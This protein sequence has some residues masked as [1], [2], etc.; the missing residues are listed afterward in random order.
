[1]KT[2]LLL[3]LGCVLAL[4]LVSAQES[5]SC[6]Y[7]SETGHNVCGSFLEFFNSHGGLGIFGYPLT[8]EMNDLGL[9]VQ[10]FQH[11]RMEYHPHNPPRY[12]VQ[13]GLLGDYFAPADQKARI[14]DSQKPRSNDRSRRYFPETGHSVGFSFLKFYD[15]KGG[16][17][18]F[19]YPVTEF[20]LEKGRFVQYFQ[21]A[22]M[23]WDPNQSRITLHKLGEMWIDQHPNNYNTE[24]A[25]PLMA[26]GANTPFP[27]RRLFPR[28]TPRPLC[29]MPLRD[30][31]ATRPCGYTS[32]VKMAS[33]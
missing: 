21:R 1:M 33:Q 10:Y 15:E 16:L 24:R 28:C 14:P 22:L 18:I 8:E 5:S 30:E 2:R 7:F 17:D 9:L 26:P 29:V 3:L 13:L 25:Q 6:E 23:E 32:M 4:S 12:Q 11:A 31:G 27:P 19:G 20:I